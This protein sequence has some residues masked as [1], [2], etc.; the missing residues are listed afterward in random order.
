MWGIEPLPSAEMSDRTI[1]ARIREIRL[2]ELRGQHLGCALGP[3]ESGAFGLGSTC[4]DSRFGLRNSHHLADLI[5]SV[6]MLNRTDTRPS[7]ASCSGSTPKASL[8][9]LPAPPRPQCQCA[10]LHPV[11][12]EAAALCATRSLPVQSACAP[13]NSAP[14]GSTETK[15]WSGSMQSLR[16]NG[17]MVRPMLRLLGKPARL[18]RRLSAGLPSNQNLTPFA[19]RSSCRRKDVAQYLTNTPRQL[20]VGC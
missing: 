15:H 7:H 19:K 12:L 17:L 1:R 6:A 20:D 10:T 13:M 18:D 2:S 5:V 11:Q 3:R 16:N 14:V 4:L 8:P 9:F